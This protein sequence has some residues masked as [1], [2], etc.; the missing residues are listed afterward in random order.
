MEYKLDFTKKAL[1][2][3]NK[4]Q[5]QS[6]TR[7]FSAIQNLKKSETWGDV[8]K[9]VN[10]QFDYRLRV[11]NYRVLFTVKEDLSVV[12]NELLIEEVKKRDERT[13]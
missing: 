10:H 8:R 13:Y 2:Q 3:L 11:G 6:R 5:M 4:I 1:K 9:L 12:V 7:I